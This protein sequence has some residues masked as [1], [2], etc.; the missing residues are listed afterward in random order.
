MF[1]FFLGSLILDNASQASSGVEP[2]AAFV[3]LWS[4]QMANG[5]AV[6]KGG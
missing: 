5:V 6:E 2:E 1:R 4:D 3:K